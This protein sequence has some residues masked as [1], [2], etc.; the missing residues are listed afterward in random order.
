[1]RYRGA[2]QPSVRSGKRMIA[3]GKKE[4]ISAINCSNQWQNL[5]FANSLNMII[6]DWKAFSLT[7]FLSK[8]RE[9]YQ[10]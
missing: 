9:T 3:K 6:K 10:E 1:M 7:N 2:R 8:K 5:G 4:K